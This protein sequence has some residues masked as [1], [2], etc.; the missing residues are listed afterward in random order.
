MLKQFYLKQNSVIVAVIFALATALYLSV[1]VASPV[2]DEFQLKRDLVSNCASFSLPNNT[3]R[4]TLID[5]DKGV[6]YVEWTNN[7]SEFNTILPYDPQTGFQG[8]SQQAKGLL[9]HV[10]QANDE[11]VAGTCEDFKDIINGSKPLPER[12][13]RKA[14]IQ[15]AIEFINQYCK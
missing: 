14:N 13:G 3:E 8:C 5:S 15:G 12:G 2:V 9:L 7:G 4:N 1:A 11:L 6:V 10:K